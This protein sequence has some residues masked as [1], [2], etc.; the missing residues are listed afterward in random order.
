MGNGLSQYVAEAFMCYFETDLEKMSKLTRIWHRYVDD[1]FAVIKKSETDK[2]IT[3]INNKFPSIQFTCEKEDEHFHALPFVDIEVK[4][5]IRNFKFAVFKKTSSTD[6]YITNDSYCPYSEKL[7][8]FHSMIYRLSRLP[9]SI[10]K[11]NGEYKQILNTVNINGYVKSIIDRLLKK[12]S[13]KLKRNNMSTLFENSRGNSKH[14]I[15]HLFAP[16]ITHK[17]TN[18]FAGAEMTMVQNNNKLKL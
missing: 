15:T 16:N 5:I 1:I 14:R 6:R 13:I 10:E 8:A 4:R 7:A 17:K 3:I 12:H 2:I 9:L 18:I 11:Y